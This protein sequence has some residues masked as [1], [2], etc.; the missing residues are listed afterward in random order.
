MEDLAL[1]SRTATDCI[2][3][4]RIA[5]IRALVD[6][7]SPYSTGLASGLVSRT[8]EDLEALGICK[9]RDTIENPYEFTTSA[10]G[11]MAGAGLLSTKMLMDDTVVS[12]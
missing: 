11:L 12:G 7:A 9:R 10:E 8:L 6:G 4:V 1:V 3:G 2:P 5:V